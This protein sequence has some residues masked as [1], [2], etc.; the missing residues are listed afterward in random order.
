MIVDDDWGLGAPPPTGNQ[1]LP[2]GDAALSF[3]RAPSVVGLGK[4]IGT[5]VVRGALV[6]AGLF[7]VGARGK[8]LLVYTAGATLAVECGVLVWGTWQAYK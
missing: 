6:G 4:V 1:C 8:Q 2:S 7:V 3:V 5:M